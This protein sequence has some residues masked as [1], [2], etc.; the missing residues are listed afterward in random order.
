MKIATF[1]ANGI[2]ARLPLV[3]E[4]LGK[5]F[6]DVLCLQETKVQDVD[7]PK[8]PFEDMDYHCVFRGQKAYNGVAIVSKTAPEGVRFGFGDGDAGEESRLI[9]A[10][11]RGVS[12]VNSYVP[13]GYAP[14]SDKF[15][16][17]LLWFEKLRHFFERFFQ[18]GSH[19]VWLG[20][21]NVAP[22]P[23]DVYDPDRLI[24]GVGF[25]PEEHRCLG[26]VK[27]WG[28]VDVFRKHEPGEKM[29]SFWD[30]RIPNAVGR[31]LGWRLDH[32]WASASMAQVSTRA[33]IDVAPRLFPRPSD[34]TFVVAEFDIDALG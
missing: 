3:L 32:I 14:D 15:Q 27:S 21:F 33:W 29:Y 11:V 9:T 13:Q 20:D 26:E 28:F 30:Y 31:G 23:I 25:H 17:K 24:G 4:W 18:P 8:K 34:H 22:D 16:Y 6:P 1:N 12:I 19:L 7:F 5:E 2:R 10:V